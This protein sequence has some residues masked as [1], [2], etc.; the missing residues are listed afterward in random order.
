MR[1]EFILISILCAVFGITSAQNSVL[2]KGNIKD[3]MNQPVNGA[4]LMLKANDTY[5]ISDKNGNFT[6][7]AVLPDTLIVQ[8]L[9]FKSKREFIGN[10]NSLF[11]KII[12][13]PS[14]SSLQEVI[15]STGYQRL[16]KERV[17]G[18]FEIIDKNLINQRTSADVLSRLEGTSSILFDKNSN[19]PPLTIRGLSTINGPTSPLIIVDNFPF[20]GDIDNINPNDIQNITLLKDAAAASIWGTRA[21]NGVIVITTKKGNYN[22]KLE[23]N[24]TASLTIGIKPNLNYLRQLSPSD[25]IDVEEYL[26]KLGAY[27]NYIN[28]NSK[29]IVSPVVEILNKVKNGETSQKI[30]DDQIK[31]LRKHDLRNDYKKYIYQKSA[32]QQYA[33]NLNGGT[34]KDKYYFSLGFDKDISN[35][36]ALYNRFNLKLKN[37]YKLMED[38]ELTTNL[39]YTWNKSLS[40]RQSYTDNISIYGLYPY[41]SLVDEQGNAVPVSRY[42]SSFLDTAGKGLLQNWS[43]YPLTDYLHNRTNLVTNELLVS[44]SAT[45]KIL[46]GLK[47][48]VLYQFEREIINTSTLHDT[49]GFYSKDLINRYSQINYLDRTISYNIPLGGILDRNLSTM[50]ANNI[51]GQLSYDNAIGKHSLT[52]II[53]AEMREERIDANSHRVYGYN[54]NVLTTTNVDYV[55]TFPDFVT[56]SSHA[57]PNGLSEKSLLNRFISIYSNLA[58]TY[59]NRYTVSGSARR[60][61]SNLFGVNTNNKWTPLWSAGLGWN[62]SNEPYYNISILPLL[63]LRASYGVSG[64]VD[65]S[66]S[67]VTTLLYVGIASNYSNLKQASINQYANPDLRWERDAM[68][69]IG[70]DFSLKNRILYGSVDYYC[71][72]GKDLF[73]AYPIDYTTG[74]GTS[75]VITRNVADMQG[76]GLDININ[77]ALIQT[78]NFNWNTGV[79]FNLNHNKVIKYYQPS[80]NGF[81]YLSNGETKISPM[82]GQSVYSVV[83]LKWAG[84]DNQGNPVGIVNGSPSSDYSAI[85]DSTKIADLIFNGSATPTLYGAW[86]NTFSCKRFSLSFS[87]SYKF[88][89]YFRRSSIDYSLLFRNTP[90]THSDYLLRWQ[91]PGDEKNTNVPS[92]VYPDNGYRGAV[93]NYSSL[94]VNK[95][96]NIR[97]QFINLSYRIPKRGNAG[98]SVLKH[99]EAFVNLANIGLIWKANSDGIDPDYPD[100]LPPPMNIAFGLKAS[101]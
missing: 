40:G 38:L 59:D 6:I 67:A 24:A 61:A 8:K 79:I 19:R 46:K 32:N 13:N 92:L 56:G 39:Q 48:N 37:S 15:V 86:N 99:M 50:T 97:L 98:N 96:D 87:I 80:N 2:L 23:I 10:A 64:N 85:M 90:Q 28:N 26:F 66:M 91:H 65:Q 36:D 27:D 81:D 25:E 30:A 101:F 74:A 16:P 70:F 7:K 1:K 54:A 83:S 41:S 71:K 53:G 20:N 3:N 75:G 60:D 34:A 95:G 73:G 4:T 76:K 22:T 63:K 88:G 58:Y 84:L 72:R 29:P 43:F 14:V 45:Y 69:N 21:G 55:H 57:I 9:G 17:T 42:Q 52:A 51:R 31:E 5:A 11:V 44:G 78:K 49:S 35:L 12:L 89:Y 18:S 77:S 94:L 62:I 82:A 33:I 93:Y 47:A 100:V 68:L